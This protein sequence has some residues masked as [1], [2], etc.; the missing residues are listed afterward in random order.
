[1]AFGFVIERFGLFRTLLVSTP[2]NELERGPSFWVGIAFVLLGVYACYS[3]H[4]QFRKVLKTFR[5][6]EIPERYS[7]LAGS[8]VNLTIASLGVVLTVYLFFTT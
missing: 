4:M 8:I 3:S 5:P 1:M 2:T 7:V 6:V